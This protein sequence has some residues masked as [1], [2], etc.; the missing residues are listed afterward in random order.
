[1]AALIALVVASHVA[2]AQTQST[3]P[4]TD[5][6]TKLNFA[7]TLGGASLERV[8]NYAGPPANRPEQGSSYFYMT[9][10]KM[11]ITVQVF[12][13][14][15]R[16]AA[17]SNNPI[18]TGEFTDELE[19]VAQQV[20]SSGYT[21]FERPSVPS[22]CTYGSMTFR[23]ITYSALTQS[24]MRVYSKLLLTGYQNHFVKVR[25]DWGQALQQTSSDA[26]AALQSFIPALMH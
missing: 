17:G 7:A 22:T 12:D 25:I 11:L 15:R 24:N 10:K 26:D 14:G 13:G 5:P 3:T 1:M 4:T 20:Q 6:G 8:V 9:P 21:H 2:W 18:V 23:C 16:V 19:S